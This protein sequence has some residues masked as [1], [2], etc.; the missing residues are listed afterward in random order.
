MPWIS[1]PRERMAN[2]L[3]MRGHATMDQI[4]EASFGE[5]PPKGLEIVGANDQR[6]QLVPFMEYVAKALKEK[7]LLQRLRVQYDVVTKYTG[8]SRQQGPREIT[9]NTHKFILFTLPSL[10]GNKREGRFYSTMGHEA[11][12]T[13]QGDHYYRAESVFGKEYA[14]KVQQSQNDTKSRVLLTCLFEQH[15]LASNPFANK[16]QEHISYLSDGDEVQARMHQIVAE[17]YQQWGRL[18]QNREELW[19]AFSEAGLR[20]PQGVAD[21][22]RLSPTIE[23]TRAVFGR[24]PNSAVADIKIHEL[25]LVQNELTPRGHSALWHD[26]LPAMYADLIEMYGD[27]QGGERFGLGKNERAPVREAIAAQREAELRET[28]KRAKAELD[29]RRAAKERQATEERERAANGKAELKGVAKKEKA[30][31]AA[32]RPMA[33]VSPQSTAGE[34]TGPVAASAAD[35]NAARTNASSQAS[36]SVDAHAGA[37]LPVA[38]SQGTVERHVTKP[39]VAIA[40]AGS[41]T[42]TVG[43]AQP[44]GGDAHVGSGKA[45]PPNGGVVEAS[46]GLAAHA[47]SHA[48]AKVHG[49]VGAFVRLGDMSEH[50]AQPIDAAALALDGAALLSRGNFSVGTGLLGQATGA[51]SQAYRGYKEDGLEG[52][53][54]EGGKGTANTVIAG[55]VLAPGSTW[56]GLKSI[57]ALATRAKQVLTSSVEIKKSFDAVRES[58]VVLKESATL[59]N[60]VVQ[61]KE[62]LSLANLEE[63]GSGAA[64]FAGK[65]ALANSAMGVASDTVD[66]ATGK[67]E[68]TT[69]NWAGTATD[70]VTNLDPLKAIS[71]GKL[72]VEKNMDAAFSV[73]GLSD[74]SGKSIAERR[75]EVMNLYE[76]ESKRFQAGMID[77]A[78]RRADPSDST[79]PQ[80]TD[81]THL[82]AVSGRLAQYLPEGKIDGHDVNTEFNKIDMTNAKNYMAYKT[83]INQAMIAQEKI[84]EE[85]SSWVPRWMR[86]GESSNKYNEAESELKLLKAAEAEFGKFETGMLAYNQ[87]KEARTEA[88]RVKAQGLDNTPGSVTVVTQPTATAKDHSR[89]V[90]NETQKLQGIEKELAELL[91]NGERVAVFVRVAEMKDA[92]AARLVNIRGRLIEEFKGAAKNLENSPQYDETSNGVRQFEKQVERLENFERGKIKPQAVQT[93]NTSAVSPVESSMR[94]PHTNDEHQWGSAPVTPSPTKAASRAAATKEGGLG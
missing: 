40:A 59:A 17:G 7:P 60:V 39:E 49:L 11:I 73:V 10:F 79:K 27:R 23:Q 74:G 77:P 43:V 14:N 66:Y 72:S 88:A 8:F 85:N 64:N 22:L 25:N 81:Y 76:Q 86:G 82:A 47:E 83:A 2:Q 92:E 6:V 61:G 24:R 65:M 15:A 75:Q 80:M 84:K 18:P 20:P 55:E 26:T 19:V 42:V 34:A 87:N 38:A 68:L 53:A 41:D 33:E 56:A 44:K 93:E 16:E 94:L 58:V 67:K 21:Q 3:L 13:L 35:A 29:E 12:H 70:A 32:E 71:F 50:G 54:R 30:A 46:G 4:L 78:F 37:T 57:P 69:D 48:P 51:V 36:A 31:P 62:A 45:S 52:A 63:L 9:I 1:D 89:K 90:M 91:D 28:E 5:W